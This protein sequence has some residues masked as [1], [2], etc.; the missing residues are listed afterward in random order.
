M[1]GLKIKQFILF[2]S[3]NHLQQ[4]Q[5]HSYK[6]FRNNKLVDKGVLRRSAQVTPDIIA[7]SLLLF[8]SM[9]KTN[10]KE[11]QEIYH[12]SLQSLSDQS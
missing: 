10:C 12:K 4:Q 7:N 2:T 1:N 8:T 9:Y 3:F 6:V 11:N 5:Q